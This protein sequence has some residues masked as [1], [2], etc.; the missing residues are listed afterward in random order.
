MMIGSMSSMNNSYSLNKNQMMR[1][2]PAQ[3]FKELDSNADGS[4]D[5]TEFGTLASEISSMT[6]GDISVDDM[7][8]E[9]DS[10]GD[11]L[12]SETEFK[13]AKPPRMQPG[14]FDPSM[15][16]GASNQKPPAGQ[17][18]DAESL[19]SELD[20]NGDNSIDE[21][22]LESMAAK[23]SQDGQTVSVKDLMGKIDSDGDSLVSLD[24]LKANEPPRM[25][26]GGAN[27]A[28]N[29]GMSDSEGENSEVVSNLESLLESISDSD[30]ETADAITNLINLLKK[31]SSKSSASAAKSSLSYT[32]KYANAAYN[33]TFGLLNSKL[34]S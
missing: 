6:G 25:R 16:K 23:I 12:V 30:S 34:A 28:K 18:P 33:K 7:L 3:K 15:I 26:P 17:A 13:S 19:F 5:K 32:S 9:I 4:L 27:P 22:E 10:D 21:T 29:T 8:S 2:D 20:T 1:P 24:E 11:G 14:G 31:K